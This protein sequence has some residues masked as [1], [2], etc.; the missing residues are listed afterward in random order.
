M[1][2]KS[3]NPSDRKIRAMQV[4]E[5]LR[6]TRKGVHELY[7]SGA[8]LNRFLNKPVNRL[9]YYSLSNCTVNFVCR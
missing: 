7:P 8:D 3:L 4:E 5:K 9:A 1:K 2:G 6:R